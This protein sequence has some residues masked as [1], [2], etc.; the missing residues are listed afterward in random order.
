MPLNVCVYCSSSDKLEP[1][2]YE[3]AAGVGA[4]LARH[5]HT[6]VYGG[7]KTGLMGAV[8]KAAHAHGG[9]VIG[10]IPDFLRTVELAY[11]D[12][13]ELVV[14]ADVRQR[15]AEMERR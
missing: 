14:T 5:G 8:A 10:V 6:V 11:E 1:R 4:S 9:R 13:D 12:A 15:K 7:G 2:F 3:A